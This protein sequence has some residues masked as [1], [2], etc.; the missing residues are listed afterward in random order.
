MKKLDKTICMVLDKLQHI[1][2]TGKEDKSPFSD[3][4]NP[5]QVSFS[6]LK[7]VNSDF[8]SEI[9]EEEF[10]SYNDTEKETSK[11]PTETE[12]IKFIDLAAG[13]SPGKYIKMDLLREQILMPTTDSVSEFKK[14][15]Q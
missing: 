6:K 11:F 7:K 2:R 15:R 13:D 9:S 14:I 8:E 4:Q 3:H 12:G 10:E 1:S 5:K